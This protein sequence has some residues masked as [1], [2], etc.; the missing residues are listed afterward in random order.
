[1]TNGLEELPQANYL[2]TCT[3]GGCENENISIAITA[4]ANDP[5]VMCGPCGRMIVGLVAA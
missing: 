5:L 4:A 3:T 1:M 2:A